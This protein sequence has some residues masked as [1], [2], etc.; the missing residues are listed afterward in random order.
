MLTLAQ[1]PPGPAQLQFGTDG[2]RNAVHG[3]DSDGS[4]RREIDFFF[5]ARARIPIHF[6]VVFD[7]MVAVLAVVQIPRRAYK[8]AANPA[9]AD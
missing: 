5:G 8:A 7:R 2:Q 4:A 3:S 6:R 1:Q 9:I